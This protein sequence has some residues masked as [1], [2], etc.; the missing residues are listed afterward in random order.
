MR[1]L[2]AVRGQVRL[3]LVAGRAL[4]LV[5]VVL[6]AQGV[7]RGHGAVPVHLARAAAQSMAG[8]AAG[9]HAAAL[10]EKDTAR[11]PPAILA[12]ERAASVQARASRKQVVVNAETD[13]GTLVT[14]NPDG[15]FTLTETSGPV[16]VQRNGQWVPIDTTLSRRADGSIAAAATA[17]SVNFSGGGTAP[18]V[19]LASGP[20][21][22]ALT[23]PVRLPAPSL[24]GPTA[25]Y[26]NVL[27][28]VDLKLT[29]EASGFSEILVVKTRE[30][31]ANPL[32]SRLTL[33]VKAAGVHVVGAPGGG[34]VAVDASGAVRFHSNPATMWDSSTAGAPQG[35]AG[36]A[37][38]AAA[39]RGV[40]AGGHAARFAVTA[41]GAAETLVPDHN[42][43]SSATTQYPVYIDPAWSGNPSQLHWARIS[44]NGWD[45][46]D[47]T[48]TSGGDNPRAGLDD[49]PYGAGETARTFYQMNTGGSTGT[50]GIGGAVVTAATLS[51]NQAWAASGTDTPV[52]VYLACVPSGN[53]WDENHLNWN[54][55]PCLGTFQ[56]E[57]SS[58]ETSSGPS[59]ATLQFNILDAAR[60]AA[61]QSA[62]N[63]T[64]EVRSPQEGDATEWKQFQSGGGASISV[65]YMR[66][67]DFVNG[68]GNPAITPSSTDAGTTYTTSPTPTLN[69]TAEDTDGE[70]VQTVYQVWQGNAASPTTLAATG[71]APSPTTYA[72]SGG[73]WTVPAGLPDGL[74]EWRASATNPITPSNPQGLWAGW[75]PWHVFKVDTR[76]PDA[77]GV[78]SPQFP[79]DMEGAAFTAPGTFTFTNDWADNV[80]GYLFS[81]DG[82]LG[83][84]V[85]N[86]ASPPQTW[87]GPGTPQP[88]KVYWLE[89][90]NGDGTGAEVTNGTASALIIPGTTGAHRIYAKSV[91]QAGN[92]SNEYF[93]PFYAGSTQP[94]FIYGDQL[95]NGYT[96]ADGTVVPAAVA[97]TSGAQLTTQGDCCGVRFADGKQAYLTVGTAVP[98]LGDTATM[99]F[100]VPSA[101]YWDI[102]ANLTQSPGYGVYSLTLDQGSARPA[103]LIRGFDADNGNAS[104][105]TL[106]YRDL[107]IPEDAGGT[108]VQLTKGIHTL[109]LAITGKDAGSV[110]YKAGID[111]LR[112]GPVPA[113]C[114]VTDLSGCL[115]NTAISPDTSTDVAN[116]DGW[117]QS[118]SASALASAGWTPGAALTVDGAPLTL[119]N[120]GAGKQDN[121]AAGG[122]KITIPARGV[123]N[124]GNAVVFLGFATGDGGQG[125]LGAT[126]RIDYATS[127]GLAGSG[128]AFQDYTLDNVPNWVGGPASAASVLTPY[129]NQGGNNQS[130]SWQPRISAIAVPLAHPGCPVASITLPVVSYGVSGTS[131]A[132]HILALGIRASSFTGAT[133]TSGSGYANAANWTGTYAARQDSTT[134][135]LGTVTIR[136][137]ARVSAGNGGSGGQV[138]VHLSNALGVAPVTI[139]DAS[140]AAQSSGAVPAGPPVQLT[141]N[142]GSKA[143]VIPA[144]G[145]ITTDPVSY[146]VAPMS[147]LLVSIHLAT[148][149][150]VP[151]VHGTAMVHSWITAA[152]TDAVMDTSG[153]PFTATGSATTTDQ[154]YLTGID[155]TSSGSTAGTVVL[156]GDRTVNAD[157]SQID[158]YNTTGD[159]LAADLATLPG[160]NGTVPYGIVAEGESNWS[161]GNNKLP[162]V[163]GSQ[164]PLS[165]LNPVDRSVLTAANVRTV[166]LSTGASDILN[167]NGASATTIE[168]ELA[169]LALEIRNFYTDDQVG[170]NQ[171]GLLTV[172][173]ATIPPDAKFTS[174][175]EAVREAVNRYILGAGGYL[176]GNADGVIDFAAAVSSDG[177]DTGATVNPAYLNSGSGYPDSAYYQALAQQYIASTNPGSGTVGIQPDS[178][179]RASQQ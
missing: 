64:F 175:Q 46:F 14:A 70:N 25:T 160:N 33:G 85:Y 84:T 151:P 52:D 13:T 152:G 131:P 9:G 125:L 133:A 98:A 167:L 137:P 39:A 127:C 136:M 134:S 19:T 143:L 96:A 166:V 67:P 16:R 124:D 123:A 76:A 59:P 104:L 176:G 60:K 41:N 17:T 74:Y 65:T 91:D 75:S 1:E 22:V 100:Y 109:T 99:S 150:S 48:S 36:Q 81:L 82:D 43:L 89:A 47:S 18:M 111:V 118:F 177:T 6:A 63:V 178:V 58:H 97:H 113:S 31:A 32:L 72:P 117:R 79:N 53:I 138:R 122:Q 83:A 2:R 7:W 40:A 21:S 92:T 15:T 5:G 77:P 87:T 37:V 55:Q 62:S 69:I 11:V 165:A 50:S 158:G 116:A 112:L 145:D 34:I 149:V 54:S 147:T 4:V 161:A 101:G 42:L 119:P 51:I 90:D 156:Y 3:R 172:Y 26:G 61:S 57:R 105:V 144:G 103:T 140:L 30:A 114:P 120:Y 44:S 24:S 88:G 35:T 45:I 107:G 49:W 170:S 80:Q 93:Y 94:S 129:E 23:F 27:P 78:A 154:P 115:N 173:V 126:G 10:A 106:S 56:D 29:A 20:G 162:A 142:G 73:P 102:G 108:P 128:N 169:A 168:K 159:D 121:I 110:G 12:A 8:P 157:T 163:A 132:L 141:F 66:P 68:T 71:Q 95:V 164:N 148:A 38:A 135:A 153:S 130:T 86:P 146:P 139:D 179:H 28:G 174:A 155:V 171:T